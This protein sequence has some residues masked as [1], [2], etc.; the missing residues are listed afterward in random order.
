MI[1]MRQP[2]HTSYKQRVTHSR[3]FK[4]GIHKY[5]EHRKGICEEN[6]NI[7]MYPHYLS[8]SCGEKKKK[9]KKKKGT[10][11]WVFSQ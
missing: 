4:R 7:G 5:D 10:R 9:K 8:S 1:Y 2:L 6:D 11:D 3:L